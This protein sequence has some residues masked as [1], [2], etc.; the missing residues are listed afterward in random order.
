MTWLRRLA[1]GNDPW[2]YLRGASQFGGANGTYFSLMKRGLIDQNGAITDEGR[3]V[4][5]SRDVN[6]GK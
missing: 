3:S 1:A 2:S 4:V 6:G 5:E